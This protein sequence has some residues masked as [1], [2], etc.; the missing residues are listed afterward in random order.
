MYT[1]FTT[2]HIEVNRT[3]PTMM[4]MKTYGTCISYGTIHVLGMII[5]IL[6]TRLSVNSNVESMMYT[7]QLR[8]RV[9]CGKPY[10]SYPLGAHSNDLQ[11][12]RP[13]L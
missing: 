3:L 4:S 8:N 13:L 2:A 1:L 11:N 5:G 7:Q 12:T 6:R 10:S 9:L